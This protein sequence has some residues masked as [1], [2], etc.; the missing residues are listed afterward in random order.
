[1]RKERSTAALILGVLFAGALI[2]IAAMGFQMQKEDVAQ[3]EKVESEEGVKA[4]IEHNPPS[5]D[6]VPEGPLGEQI[7]R[8]YELTNDIRS[9]TW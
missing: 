6:D 1:M 2:V 3:P 9:V 8:G 5:L 4:T 7:L